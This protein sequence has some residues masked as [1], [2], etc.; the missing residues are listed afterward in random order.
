MSSEYVEKDIYISKLK[1]FRMKYLKD[2]LKENKVQIKYKSESKI[3]DFKII[4]DDAFEVD[5]SGLNIKFYDIYEMTF[6]ID[7]GHSTDKTDEDSTDGTD[8][9]NGGNHLLSFVFLFFLFLLF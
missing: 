3:I 5:L 6:E 7:D 2:Q 8:K 4:N 9:K 1:F